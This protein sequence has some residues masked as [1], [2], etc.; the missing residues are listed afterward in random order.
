TILGMSES[1]GQSQTPSAGPERPVTYAPAPSPRVFP[2]GAM[3]FS[4]VAAILTLISSFVPLFV[5]D[6]L[7]QG[8]VKLSLVIDGWGFKAVAGPGVKETPAKWGA[9]AING[10]PLVLATVA[11]VAAGILAMVALRS[12]GLRMA[13]VVTSTLAAGL[14]IGTGFT[15]I[16]QAA[17]WGDSLQPTG[18]TSGV[19]TEPYFGLG[20]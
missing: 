18:R 16:M 3:I 19:T 10:G 6:I 9:L 11:L 17:S 8:R 1:L 7:F 15:I 14:L 2:P 20:I 12:A 13:S 5:G 4:V